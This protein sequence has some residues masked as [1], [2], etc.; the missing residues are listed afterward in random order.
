V[1]R[2]AAKKGNAPKRAAEFLERLLPDSDEQ[3]GTAAADRKTRRATAHKMGVAYARATKL[4]DRIEEELDKDEQSAEEWEWE[5]RGKRRESDERSRERAEARADIRQEVWVEERHKAM[6]HQD[7]LLALTVVTTLAAIVLVYLA[8]EH[9]QIELI[10]ASIF[11]TLLSGAEVYV[12]RWIRGPREG[13][14]AVDGIP[15]EP[16]PFRWGVLDLQ[17]EDEDEEV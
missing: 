8:I 11:S 12:M 17:R 14:A 7:W 3:S 5:D 1:S 10:G 6:R 9:N 2:A 15:V 13:A 4:F 16:P